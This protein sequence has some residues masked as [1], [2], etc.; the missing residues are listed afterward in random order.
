MDAMIK[1]FRPEHLPSLAILRVSK[2]VY[3]EAVPWIYSAGHLEYR[4]VPDDRSRSTTLPQDTSGLHM[5][6]NVNLIVDMTGQFRSLE[7]VRVDLAQPL[8]HEYFHEQDD[9]FVTLF[10][11]NRIPR[12]VLRVAFKFGHGNLDMQIVASNPVVR[13]LTK[14]TGFKHVIID[15]EAIL[16]RRDDSPLRGVLYNHF[17][18]QLVT[19]RLRSLDTFF[20]AMKT[21]LKHSL[22]PGY[23]R[24]GNLERKDELA[25]MPLMELAKRPDQDYY[26]RSIDFYPTL[27]KPSKKSA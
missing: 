27:P 2:T 4:M 14:M 16:P 17:L 5:V 24:G 19:Y 15:A 22:G 3:T 20:E 18:S 25:G 1:I 8:A 13:F 11:G 6:Q 7:N 23:D 21:Q 10:G 26:E 9:E 12:K